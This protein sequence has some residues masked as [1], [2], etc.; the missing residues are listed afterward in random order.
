MFFFALQIMKK[1]VYSSMDG[2]LQRRYT[3]QRL[4]IFPEND[5]P[6]EIIENISNQIRQVR[7]VP[8]RLD[9]IPE[10][11]VAEFPKLV[12]LPENYVIR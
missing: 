4:H 3:M 12:K 9:H 6:K 8:V 5:V 1:A 11:E 10:K 2:N 7:P